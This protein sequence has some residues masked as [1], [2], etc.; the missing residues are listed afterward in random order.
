M[1]RPHMSDEMRSL[2]C[3]SGP[4]SIKTTFLPALASTAANVE[5]EAPAPA[6]TTSTFSCVAIS[7]PLVRRNVRHVR[8][9]EALISLYRA[10]DDVGGV[11]PQDK[12]NEPGRR[13][14]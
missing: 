5:P 4:W 7:P 10:V 12:I 14:L 13:A 6:M 8:D 2:S 1:R 3:Q 9:A 11:A